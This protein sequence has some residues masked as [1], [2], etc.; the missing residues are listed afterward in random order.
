MSAIYH[1]TCPRC[2]ILRTSNGVIPPHCRSCAQKQPVAKLVEPIVGACADP[3]YDPDMWFADGS[4]ES[5]RRILAEARVVCVTECTVRAECLAYAKANREQF[6]MWGG[7]TAIQISRGRSDV[8]AMRNGD[9][10]A[11]RRRM[12]AEGMTDV[13]IAEATGFNPSTIWQWRTSRGL[14][15]NFK[16][17]N[18]AE[19]VTA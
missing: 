14:P 17:R 16:S 11:E 4:K 18:H 7:I 8:P 15:R 3:T 1:V 19:K 6:G 12:H 10:E 5:G 9:V 2:G 13:A